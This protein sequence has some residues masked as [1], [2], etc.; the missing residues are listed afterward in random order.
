MNM[1][2][3]HLRERRLGWTKH[4]KSIA[5]VTETREFLRCLKPLEFK[6]NPTLHPAS[7][8]KLVERREGIRKLLGLRCCQGILCLSSNTFIYPNHDRMASCLTFS[9]SFRTASN[10]PRR[11]SQLQ[12]CFIGFFSITH[13]IKYSAACAS[14]SMDSPAMGASISGPIVRCFGSIP[15]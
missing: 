8:G 12:L 6:W 15:Q 3:F 1:L 5:F 11:F 9:A 13:E 7:V 4:Q 14:R 10:P 2:R